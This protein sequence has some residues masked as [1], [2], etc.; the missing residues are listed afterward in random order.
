MSLLS[1]KQIASKSYNL[2]RNTINAWILMSCETLRETEGE[3]VLL[4]RLFLFLKYKLTKTM[5][6]KLFKIALHK[7]PQNIIINIYL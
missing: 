4:A 1:A 5:F 7:I 3:L 6:I 2:C